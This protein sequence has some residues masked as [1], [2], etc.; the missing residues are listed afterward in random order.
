[1]E[2]FTVTALVIGAIS[3]AFDFFTGPK[4]TIFLFTLGA[5]LGIFF[6]SP[7]ERGIKRLS[8]FFYK[9]EKIT[10]IIVGAMET[11]VAIFIPFVLFGILGLLA[12]TAYHYYARIAE[13]HEGNPSSHTRQGP[14]D[15]EH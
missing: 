2:V 8:S 5:I 10:Q 3:S 4:F 9:Q 7:I 11:I 6:P 13:R 15:E 12:G 1:M 14:S